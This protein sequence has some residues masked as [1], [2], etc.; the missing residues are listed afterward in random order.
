MIYK[1]LLPTEE[2]RC[3]HSCL[4][5]CHS[6]STLSQLSIQRPSPEWATLPLKS[7]LRLLIALGRKPHTPKPVVSGPPRLPPPCP[8]S[9]TVPV[10]SQTRLFAV[11]WTGQLSPASVL[12]SRSAFW[13]LRSAHTGFLPGPRSAW[14]L[15]SGLLWLWAS[16][17]TALSQACHCLLPT[18]SPLRT[19]WGPFHL[20][21]SHTL[22][23]PRWPPAEWLLLLLS[24]E[25]G[26]YLENTEEDPDL[27]WRADRR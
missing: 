15:S 7:L 3:C 18:H 26:A 13:P 23:G 24:L 11:A 12:A 5:T 16:L 6:A 14:G 27:T 20:C 4:P 2:L 10:S 9:L 21:L 19:G 25:D 1:P 8:S 22:P 17:L